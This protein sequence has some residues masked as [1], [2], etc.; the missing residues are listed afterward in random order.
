[1]STPPTE[2]ERVQLRPDDADAEGRRSP[3]VRPDGDESATGAA[4]PQVRDRER[5]DDEADEREHG[6]PLRMC[7]GVEV[8]PEER[9]GADLRPGDPASASRVV[10]DQALDDERQSQR[11]DGEVD[12]SRSQRG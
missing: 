3:L 1:M 10:E 4:A 11:R 7:R 9:D 2:P 5:E 8:E 6:V 12:S